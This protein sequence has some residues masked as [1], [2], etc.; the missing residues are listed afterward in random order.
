[1]GVRAA[2]AATA[3]GVLT[4]LLPHGLCLPHAPGGPPPVALVFRHAHA[5]SSS[6]LER[7]A[8]DCV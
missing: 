2:P 7:L 4:Q 6:P 3:A 1:M 8:G 5:A